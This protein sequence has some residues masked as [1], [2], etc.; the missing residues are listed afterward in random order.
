[1]QVH[2]IHRISFLAMFL[3]SLA[4][5]GTILTAVVPILLTGQV[6]PPARDEGTQAHIFQVSIVALLP[7]GLIFCATADWER[8]WRVGRALVIPAV[9]V[10]AAFALLYYFEHFIY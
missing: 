5:L 9:A 8:P 1:M 4:A 6:P 3:F 7:V 2:R 10:L